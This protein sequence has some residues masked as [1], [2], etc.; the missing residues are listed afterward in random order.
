MAITIHV[1]ELME[2]R[3][4]SVLA[5]SQSAGIAYNTALSLKRGMAT[6]VDLAT[7]DKLCKLF[8]CQPGDLLR[9]NPNS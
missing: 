9:H 6:R 3:G 7:L 1:S 8:Q 2:K 4:L 5:L